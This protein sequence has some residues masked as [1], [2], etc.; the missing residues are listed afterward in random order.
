MKLKIHRESD[1]PNCYFIELS[2][3]RNHLCFSSDIIKY[4]NI[5][6][7]EYDTIMKQHN[8]Y[9]YRAQQWEKA[10]WT[11]KTEEDT[12]GAIRNLEPYLIMANLMGE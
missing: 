5:S 12:Q 4:L 2:N 7:I 10:D 6:K 8:G 3:S 11:F 9:I 1:E